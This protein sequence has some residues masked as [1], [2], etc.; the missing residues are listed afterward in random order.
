MTRLGVAISFFL[1][2]V[3]AWKAFFSNSQCLVGRR[4][5]QNQCLVGRRGKGSVCLEGVFLKGS[6]C[7]E[8]AFLTVLVFAWKAFLSKS[9]FSWKAFPL[10]VSLFQRRRGTIGLYFSSVSPKNGCGRMGL[11]NYQ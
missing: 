4:F 8:G 3:F 2:S 10:K 1:K 11:L 5:D 6:V 9:V 7:L